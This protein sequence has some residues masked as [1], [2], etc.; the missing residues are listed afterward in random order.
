MFHNKRP[1]STRST[2]VPKPGATPIAKSDRPTYVP[3]PTQALEFT[4][5]QQSQNELNVETREQGQ[6]EKAYHVKQEVI[7]PRRR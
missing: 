2:Y 5:D 3:K 4:V 7:S 6:V 1:A